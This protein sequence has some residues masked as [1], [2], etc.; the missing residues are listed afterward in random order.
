MESNNPLYKAQREKAGSQTFGKYM[1]QYHWALYRILKE[2]EQENEYAVFVELHE[3]VV[4]SDSLNADE[5]N[6][7]FNQVKT[8]KSTFTEAKLIKLKNGNSVLGKLIQSSNEQDYSNKIK[9]I[10]LLATNGFKIGLKTPGTS[11]DDIRIKDISHNSLQKLSDAI[12]AELRTD[13][14]PL[15]LHFIVPD[16]PEKSTQEAIIG[17]IATIVTKLFPDSSTQAENIYR[18][19]IDELTRKGSITFDFPEWEDLL[20]N[21]ALTSITVL[22]VINQFTNRKSD[23]EVYRA[24]DSFLNELELA[25][26]AKRKW[27]QSFDRYYL[28]RLGNKNISQLD[29]TNRICSEIDKHLHQCNDQIEQLLILVT[30]DLAEKVKNS[31][32]EEHDLQTAIL[33]ELILKE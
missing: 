17:Y 5:A 19:L 20:E 22:K 13:N 4:L 16:L 6:F 25:S 30:G 8:D 26:L 29:T 7:E 15:N 12:I 3:D 28:Q 18:P 24:L 23:A 27:K 14:F 32:T 33:C 9:S 11:L 31:F 21:K 2:H 10:N 1:Y